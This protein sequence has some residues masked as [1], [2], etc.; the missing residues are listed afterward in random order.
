MQNLDQKTQPRKVFL[1]T[2]GCQMNV[3]D[4]EA[5]KGLLLERG[6]DFTDQ[7]EDAEIILLNTCS[8]RQH[9]E[10]RIFGR[11]GILAKMKKANPDTLIG[12]LGCMAQEHGHRFFR[13]IPALDLVCGPGN[14]AE[15]PDLMERIF[16]DGKKITAIDR[17]NDSEYTMDGIKYRSHNVK[18]NVNIMSGCD[19]KCTYCIV[20]FTRGVERSRCSDDIIRE[21]QELAD[22]GF[23]DVLLLGQNVNCYGKKL[24]E[25]IDFV[26]LLEKIDSKTQI[27]RI[28]FT[29]SHPKDAHVKLFECMRDLPSVCEHLHLPVQSGSSRILRRMKREHTREWYLERIQEFKSIVP[30]GSLT[31][32]I[33]VGFPGE[34]VEDFEMTKS[35]M[36]E[37]QFDSAFMF[38]YSP[39]PGTPAMKLEDDVSEK[40]KKRRLQDI[41][42]LQRSITFYRNTKLIGSEQEVLIEE[43][44]LNSDKLV[45][46]TRNFKKVYLRGGDEI[47]GKIVMVRIKEALQETLIGDIEEC[48]A[49]ARIIH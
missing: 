49:K 44:F 10:D 41:I 6:Y 21:I 38:K 45:G 8:V 37:V 12:I 17:I 42:E 7:M 19:H 25:N 2:F 47:V 9:A 15:L 34:T 5:A 29:T 43:R 30:K 27:P 35:L 23:K 16:H 1:Q 31:T 4:S 11:A 48:S 32:D 13:R 28:R 46:K 24:N 14:L 22:R 3:R 40:E 20:P 36:A 26:D 18:A 33:I 39:R